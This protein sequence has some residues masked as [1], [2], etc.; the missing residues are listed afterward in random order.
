MP[1]F[2]RLTDTQPGRRQ[3]VR[4]DPGLVNELAAGAGSLNE[5]NSPQVLDRDHRDRATWVEPLRDDTNVFSVDRPTT[6]L[7]VQVNERRFEI[8][9][10]TAELN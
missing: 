6:E 9:T 3:D 1:P 2:T 4:L 5:Q 7:P 10:E 8:T